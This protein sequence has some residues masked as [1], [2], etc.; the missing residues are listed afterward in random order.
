[1]IGF[2]GCQGAEESDSGDDSGIE[3]LDFPQ[4]DFSQPTTSTSTSSG[5]SADSGTT[6][7]TGGVDLGVTVG[8]EGTAGNASAIAADDGRY[9]LYAASYR[10]SGALLGTTC[11][12][13]GRIYFNLDYV[14]A[15]GWTH[16][17]V[18]GDGFVCG[19]RLYCE[20]YNEAVYAFDDQGSAYDRQILR[21]DGCDINSSLAHNVATADVIV[22]HSVDI[23]WYGDSFA[24]IVDQTTNGIRQ[25]SAF[26]FIKDN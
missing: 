9:L 21:S 13:T 2:A 14:P 24:W 26:Q 25:T 1:M 16:V 19:E 12:V 6:T 15:T 18:S 20:D 11:T 23:E 4:P 22:T 17:E 8:P 10:L 3:E 5:T 7:N